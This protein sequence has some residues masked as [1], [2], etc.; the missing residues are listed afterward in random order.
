MIYTKDYQ[1]DNLKLHHRSENGKVH[2]WDVEKREWILKEE[3]KN[4]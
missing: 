2:V 4:V 1:P 3:K